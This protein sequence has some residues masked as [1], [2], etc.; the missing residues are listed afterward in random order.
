MKVTIDVSPEEF[1]EL[2]VPSGKQSDLLTAFQKAAMAQIS[3]QTEEY[4]RAYANMVFGR[5]ERES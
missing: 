5:K 1:K 3:K 2:L 4:S